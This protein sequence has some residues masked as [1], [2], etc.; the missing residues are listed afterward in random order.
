M[1]GITMFPPETEMDEKLGG[2]TETVRK[3][4]WGTTPVLALTIMV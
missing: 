2:G 1:N 4:A 3:S